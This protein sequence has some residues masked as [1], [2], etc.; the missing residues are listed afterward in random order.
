MKKKSVVNWLI[1]I[2][3][4]AMTVF[5][6]APESIVSKTPNPNPISSEQPAQE[7][8][9]QY[10]RRSDNPTSTAAGVRNFF[11]FKA[12]RNKDQERRLRPN[13]EDVTKFAEFLK[14][15]KT[16]IFRLTN[17]LGCESNV[18]IIRVDENCGNSIPG[19]SFY[20]FREKEYT[21]AYLADLRFRDGILVS[22]GIL[23]QNILVKLGDVPLEN[24][25]LQSNGIKYLTDFVPQTLSSEA[26]KQFVQIIKGIRADKFEYRKALPAY[27]NMT[28]AIRVVAY[29]G[30]LY[31]NFRGW[32]FNLLDGD[33]RID[34]ILGFRIVRKD[35]DGSVT[36]LWKELDRKK[37]PKLERDKKR[38]ES[39]TPTP[40]TSNKQ[41]AEE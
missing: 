5:T 2:L 34:M 26:T 19:G 23:S 13:P 8:R 36:L 22:D 4:L 14:L 21:T 17:D 35:T 25:S 12:K 41:V 1:W 24:L 7:R 31:R 27:E 38:K 40:F 29:R 9:N 11:P 33:K 16:G 18:Y 37:S 15:P 32:I 3:F 30:S 10:G 39:I 20:S 6:Q 28:Y